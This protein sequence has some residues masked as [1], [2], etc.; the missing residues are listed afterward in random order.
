MSTLLFNSREELE[1]AIAADCQK[2][3]DEGNYNEDIVTKVRSKYLKQDNYATYL[4]DGVVKKCSIGIVS[5]ITVEM[6]R[7]NPMGFTPIEDNKFKLTEEDTFTDD[8]HSDSDH[9]SDTDFHER[10]LAKYLTDKHKKIKVVV[11]S[12]LAR[13][14]IP[15]ESITWYDKLII[16]LIVNRCEKLNRRYELP[17]EYKSFTTSYTDT[18]L[19]EWEEKYVSYSL[20]KCKFL[21]N[22]ESEWTPKIKT[23]VNLIIASCKKDNVIY[24]PASSDINFI[25]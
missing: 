19:Y 22:E 12:S 15:G 25:M 14:P 10:V 16:P 24:I 13:F 9:S 17:K 3:I 6:T 5:K 4:K 18:E 23:L 7:K 21:E 11:L 1:K 2:L 8:N 20:G